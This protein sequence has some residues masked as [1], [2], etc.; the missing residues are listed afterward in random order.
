[1]PARRRLRNLG[2]WLGVSY[3]NRFKPA[4]PLV[5]AGGPGEL[6]SWVKERGEGNLSETRQKQRYL[7]FHFCGL[8]MKRSVHGERKSWA[9]LSGPLLCSLAQSDATLK[10][11]TRR[12]QGIRH[13]LD[14]DRRKLVPSGHSNIA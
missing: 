2:A 9:S 14:I 11:L 3:L 8:F 4:G 1:M 12:L 7:L 13:D 6:F 5:F 10:I